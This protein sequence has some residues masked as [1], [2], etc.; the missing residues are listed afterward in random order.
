VSAP[1]RLTVE[2]IVYVKRVAAIKRR[3]VARLARMPTAAQLAE[4]LHI[5]Q[6]SIERISNDGYAVSST[7]NKVDLVEE[8]FK[9]LRL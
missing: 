6:R 5:S 8:V 3:I 1:R 2:Q 9:E 7:G 4:E